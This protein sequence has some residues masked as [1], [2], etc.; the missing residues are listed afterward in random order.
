MPT[1]KKLLA[2]PAPATRFQLFA[3]WCAFEPSICRV[4][5]SG[6]RYVLSVGTP[7][8]NSDKLINPAQITPFQLDSIYMA[9]AYRA[10]VRG[11]TLDTSMIRLNTYSVTIFR[12]NDPLAIGIG[13][14]H[15]GYSA[16]DAYI[17]YLWAIRR[18]PQFDPGYRPVEAN[19]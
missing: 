3:D 9:I 6:S 11:L 14:V 18:N 8:C 19:G 17:S 2:H 5:P 4:K 10:I 15:P 12:K 1:T 16:L 7:N 13:A